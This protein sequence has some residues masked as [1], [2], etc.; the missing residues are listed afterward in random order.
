VKVRHII[1]HFYA[2]ARI[3]FNILCFSFFLERQRCTVQSSI[4]LNKYRGNFSADPSISFL[5]VC[6]LCAAS[7][8]INDYYYYYYLHVFDVVQIQSYRCYIR[9]REDNE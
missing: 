1:A 9:L 6:I 7:C 2:S 5:C 3:K 4:G 8:V